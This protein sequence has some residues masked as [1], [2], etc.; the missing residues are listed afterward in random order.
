MIFQRYPI[1]L[2]ILLLLGCTLQAQHEFYVS[3]TGQDTASGS[4]HHPLSTVQMALR[5]VR[6]LRRL[7]PGANTHYTI[8]LRGGR[9]A[10]NEPIFIRPEDAG[11]F[12]SQTLVQPY[13]KEHVVFSGGRKI[14]KWKPMVGYYKGL[15]KDITTKVWVADLMGMDFSRD[16]IRQLW[17]NGKKA[18]RA[19]DT[20]GDLMN[21]IISWNK[22]ERSCWVPTGMLNSI[23]NP[24]GL[25]M[26]IHQWWAI[27]NLR[28]ASM[29]VQGDSTKLFFKD[30]ESRI[31]SEHPWPAPWLSNVTGNSAFY[32]V[33]AL[34]LLDEPGEWFHDTHADRLFYYPAAQVNMATAD[35]VAPV[36][37]TLM[38][39]QG[40]A[41]NPVQYLQFLNLEFSHTHWNRPSTHGHVP[42]QIGMYMTDA[43]R[44]KPIGVATK[45]GLDNQAWVG[46][47]PAAV[48]LNYAEQVS[49][50]QNR[51]THCAS[52]GLD[53]HKGA[54]FVE[55]QR[56]VFSDIGGSG[57]LVGVFSSPEKEIHLPFMPIDQQD[58]VQGIS[59]KHNLVTNAANEDWSCAGIGLGYAKQIEVKGNEVE[60][61]SNS[62][63]SMG[64]GWNAAK[65]PNFGN[66]I[67]GNHIHHF[68]K[69][70]YDCGGIYLLGAQAQGLVAE[71]R[72][73]SI[74]KAAYAHLPTHWFYLYADEGS[75]GLTVKDNWTPAQKFLQNAN[76]PDNLW[77]NNGPSVSEEI[78][79]SAGIPQTIGE[80]FQ[81]YRFDR[82]A[83]SQ[84]INE[85]RNEMIEL[86]VPDGILFR[87]DSLK[88]FLYKYN[89]DSSAVYS[90]KN[91]HVVYAT[92]TDIAVLEGRLKNNFAGVVIRVYHD[93]FYQFDRRDCGEQVA[94]QKWKHYILTA[95]LVRDTKLQKEYL[96]AHA[97]QRQYWP[98]V[99]KGFCNAGFQQLQL[100]RNGRQLMLVISIPAGETLD[101][102]D[103]KTRIN[104]PRMD[105]WNA[106]MKKY[107]E[108][109][110]GTVKNETWVFLTNENK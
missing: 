38:E 91:H 100:F 66:T 24:Q 18:I 101:A 67:I 16:G 77:Q 104:N 79:S 84:P 86:V 37:E 63:I 42:H 30:P 10:L 106:T 74:Y 45:P 64:W 34:E 29:V 82:S 13:G 1:I 83:P 95:N 39:I 19:K 80:M 71:N 59:I 61:V 7:K 57:M 96:D 43:Y 20:K 87:I 17:V 88:R 22:K 93:L 89:I 46:R 103:P 102:L 98:E 2:F 55:V 11:T 110:A 97:T 51:F 94:P 15:Q 70:N 62:G 3:T 48:V 109:I 25:E 41:E 8:F 60:E 75:T 81:P 69:H 6:E 40:N 78:K 105:D 53:L 27:A 90:W 107:Q 14:G 92:V 4:I 49:F 58:L 99:S 9:Y 12:T 56:N 52:T 31:Q 73:D 26:F 44:L 72:V 28:V 108:G 36:L 54:A 21:R 68:G 85:A 50:V 76:G 23:S 32:M 5:K 35:I 33:N 47:P 65:N